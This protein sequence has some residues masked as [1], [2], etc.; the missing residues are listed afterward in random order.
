MI[1][2]SDTIEANPDLMMADLEGEAVLLDMES[3][4]YFGLNEVGTSVWVLIKEP[5]TV[6]EILKALTQEYNVDEQQLQHDVMAFLEAMNA[7][8]LIQVGVAVHA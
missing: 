2:P 7:R 1:L 5:R 3:G 4:R 8:Q 6:S